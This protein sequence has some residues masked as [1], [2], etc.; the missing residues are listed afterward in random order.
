V[1]AG[2][3]APKDKTSA[4]QWVYAFPSVLGTFLLICLSP[5]MVS[6]VAWIGALARLPRA[7]VGGARASGAIFSGVLEGPVVTT[8]LGHEATAWIGVAKVTGPGRGSTTREKCRLG[9]VDGLSL[10]PD[11]AGGARPIASPPLALIDEEG[12][13]VPFRQGA[14]PVHYQLGQRTRL[15]PIP[16]DIA[17]RCGIAAADLAWG[18]WAYEE[19]WAP[20]GTHVEIAGCLAGEAIAP[21]AGGDVAR[22]H[23]TADGVHATARRYADRTMAIAAALSVLFLFFTGVGCIHS[24]LALRWDN[25]RELR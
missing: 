14:T 13:V 18:R 19:H 3:R 2:S 10:R 6:T 4:R 7:K 8:A 15:D 25:P 20:R 21:C 12:R 5:A 1:V 16:P 11:A 24:V 17:A 23:L 9:A 22:G